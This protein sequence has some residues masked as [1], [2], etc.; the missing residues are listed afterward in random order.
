MWWRRRGSTISSTDAKQ[1]T[2]PGTMFWVVAISMGLAIAA[3]IVI[4]G[5]YIPL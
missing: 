2:G 4:Y 3:G 5:A 1:G